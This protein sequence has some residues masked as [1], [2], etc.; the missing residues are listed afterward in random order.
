MKWKQSLPHGHLRGLDPIPYVQLLVNALD[1]ALDGFDA[2]EKRIGYF[3]VAQTVD[4]R[5][6]YLFFTLSQH[7][8]PGGFF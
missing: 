5:F 2:D 3:L 8:G 7:D 6:Q 4:D 1:V